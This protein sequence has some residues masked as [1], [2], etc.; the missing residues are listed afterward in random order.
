M[1]HN[2]QV[3]HA[4]TTLKT[5]EKENRLETA[6]GRVLT[7]LS[8]DKDLNIARDNVYRNISSI[9]FNGATFRHD[10]ALLNQP[11]NN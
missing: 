9:N 10:I 8:K 5:T 11:N 2:V 1:G 3:F 7:L 6:G 4:G